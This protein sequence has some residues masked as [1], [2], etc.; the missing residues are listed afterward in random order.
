MSVSADKFGF[1]NGLMGIEQSNWANFFRGLIPD[2]VIAGLDDELEVFAQADGMKVYVKAGQAMVDNHHIWITSQKELTI[3]AASGTER[4][5]L[6]VA[7]IVYGNEGLSTAV[8]DVKTGETVDD[9]VQVTGGTYEIPLAE[10]TVGASVVSIAA[11]AVTDKR[12]IFRIH[13]DTVDTWSTDTIAPLN[14]HEYRNDTV[15][16]SMTINLPAIPNDTYITS[17]SFEAGSAF[18][19][20]TITQGGTT[21]S[22]T[23]NL[24]LKGDTLTLKSKVYSLVIWWDGVYYWCASAAA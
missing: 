15:Q 23:T 2:G 13:D 8:L 5:D 10:I 12:Y 20:V 3:A 18:T 9:L 11:D 7:R 6:I 17:V 19:G 22:G 4:T 16:G 21:I 24:K 14:D 1:F